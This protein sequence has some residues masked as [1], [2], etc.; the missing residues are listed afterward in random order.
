MRLGGASNRSLANIICKTLEDYW[1]LKKN[2]VGGSMAL[3]W[4]NSSKL[5][6]FILRN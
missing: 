4:K 3:L 2:H 5:P 6:Q 1:A